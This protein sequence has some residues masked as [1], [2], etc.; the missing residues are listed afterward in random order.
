MD[1]IEDR[2]GHPLSR[3][4]EYPELD[5]TPVY[6][7]AGALNELHRPPSTS[8]DLYPGLRHGNERNHEA[9]GELETSHDDS[10]G[11]NFMKDDID[12]DFVDPDFEL[13]EEDI[14]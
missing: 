5:Y 6:P 4:N 8:Q 1:N 9:L 3:G 11:S 14:M 10:Y 7:W 12:D 2:D 13:P